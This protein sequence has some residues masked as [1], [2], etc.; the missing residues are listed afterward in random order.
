MG[1]WCSIDLNLTQAVKI[2][3]INRKEKQSN[4]SRSSF[5]SRR[6]T[7]TNWCILGKPSYHYK[8]K[9]FKKIIWLLSDSNH[10]S[11]LW[12]TYLLVICY[13]SWKC[14]G[15]SWSN[16]KRR[17]ISKSK[18]QNYSLSSININNCHKCIVGY[19]H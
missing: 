3:K 14:R 11:Y 9:D 1:K 17:S 4:I 15:I 19:D 10:F 8:T 12:R 2:L 18:S 13:L 7:W 5:D 16:K 6:A